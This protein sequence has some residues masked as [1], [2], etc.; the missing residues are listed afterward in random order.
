M[1]NRYAMYALIF[2][3][4]V[5]TNVRNILIWSIVKSAHNHV[6]DVPMNVAKCEG[7]KERH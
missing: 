6:E 4:H 2:V 3:K 7:Q 5:L 1:Q